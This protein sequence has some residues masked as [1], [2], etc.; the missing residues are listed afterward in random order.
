MGTHSCYP[1]SVSSC[2]SVIQCYPCC[3][4]LLLLSEWRQITRRDRDGWLDSRDT[5]DDKLTHCAVGI[6]SSNNYL[7]VI[8]RYR[9]SGSDEEGDYTLDIDQVTL[10]DD[11][12]SVKN[13][14]QDP[15]ETGHQSD[16]R[17]RS[18]FVE[19]L[20]LRLCPS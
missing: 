11:A 5:Y 6:I 1:L 17:L 4:S 13:N 9:M 12:R 19:V 15:E 7:T 3:V 16:V 10:E 20:D 18:S 14:I 2:V 8:F